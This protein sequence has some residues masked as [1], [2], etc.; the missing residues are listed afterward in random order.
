MVSKQFAEFPLHPAKVWFS[1]KRKFL[2]VTISFT[3][4]RFS[5]SE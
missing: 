1:D 3:Q 5:I 2:E 4:K